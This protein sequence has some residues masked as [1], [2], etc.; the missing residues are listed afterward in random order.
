MPK[1]RIS[2]LPIQQLNS[3]TVDNCLYVDKM[4]S[5]RMSA[6]PMRAVFNW[7]KEQAIESGLDVIIEDDRI[8][9]LKPTDGGTR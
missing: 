9:F 6:V 1:L 4:N 2:D 3:E 5:H 8:R 7:I